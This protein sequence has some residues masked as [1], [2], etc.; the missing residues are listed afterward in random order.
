[1]DTFAKGLSVADKL[2]KDGA[3]E[4]FVEKRYASYK[5]GIGKKIVE[6]TTDFEELAQYALHHD[7]IVNQSGRQE[8]LEDIVNRFIYSG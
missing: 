8:M 3:L 6:S 5:T 2:L 4:S 1:M 7:Q